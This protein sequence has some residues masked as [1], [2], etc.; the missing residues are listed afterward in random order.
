MRKITLDT[1]ALAQI[2]SLDAE[3]EV[4]DENGNTLGYILPADL[5]RQVMYAWAKAQF[6]DER[7][8][9][10]RADRTVHPGF[11][12]TEAIARL[13]RLTGPSGPQT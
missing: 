12:T 13:E 7:F 2:G 1:K 5:H 9:A 4:C 8:L 10:A 6:S 11:T 3:V